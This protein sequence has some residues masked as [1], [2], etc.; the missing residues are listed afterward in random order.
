MLLPVRTSV[1][2]LRSFARLT[3]RLVAIEWQS[4]MRAMR[5]TAKPRAGTLHECKMH[6]RNLRSCDSGFHFSDSVANGVWNWNP[7]FR[8]SHGV[9]RQNWQVRGLV[10]GSRR[11]DDVPASDSAIPI[12]ISAIQIHGVMGAQS[13]KADA[14]RHGFMR[15]RF[16]P[17]GVA[18]EAGCV[19]AAL[20]ICGAWGPTAAPRPCC[21]A[22]P[23][24]ISAHQSA[25]GV[26][27]TFIG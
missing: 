9:H 17:H 14:D 15:V 11:S 8:S 2:A 5:R 25:F 26:A 27:R 1:N 21:R 7:A 10:R 23:E 13:C 19:F 24:G 18:V 12:A 3:L 6:H 22:M 20:T 16:R 4:G